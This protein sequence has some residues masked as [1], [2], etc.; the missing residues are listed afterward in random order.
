MT[1]IDVYFATF[2]GI[3]VAAAVIS[4]IKAG[5]ENLREWWRNRRNPW[6]PSEGHPDA[7]YEMTAS[8]RDVFEALTARPHWTRAAKV[9]SR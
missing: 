3:C 5:V 6:F 2:I 9:G 1:V 7:D 4:L 8:E